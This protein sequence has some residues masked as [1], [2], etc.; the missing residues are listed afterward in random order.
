[1]VFEALYYKD[2]I[3]VVNPAGD[4]GIATLWSQTEAAYK[5]LESA[6]VDLSPE[7]SRI[8]V[9]ANLYGNGLPQ[10][11]RNLLWNPQIRYIVIVGKNLSGSR[12]WLLNFFEHGIEEVEFLG[13]KAFRIRVTD[14]NIDGEVTPEHFPKPPLF[15][16]LGDLGDAA[17]KDDFTKY[18][19]SLPPADPCPAERITPPPVP[20]PTVSRFPSEPRSHTIVRDTPMEAWAELIFRLVRFGYRN[21][22][23]K[24]ASGSTHSTEERVELQNVKVII[25]RPDTESEDLLRAYGFT[26]DDF[27]DDKTFIEHDSQLRLDFGSTPQDFMDYQRRMLESA[28]PADIGY[29]YGNRLR[30]Y[31]RHSDGTPVD[32]LAIA[33]RRLRDEP[34]SRHAYIS[35][36][37][38]SRDLPEGTHCP[39]FVTGFF[40]RFEDQLTFTATFR[41][42]NA[43]DAWPKNVYGLLAIQRFVADGAGMRP[44]PI[45]VISH[46]ISVDVASLEKAKRI[47]ESKTT[48]DVLDPATGKTEP[49][50][51]PNGSFAITVDKAAWE[52]VVE[53]SYNGMVLH[54]Y[55]GRSAE[56]IER[57]V[58]RDCA[59]SV[60]SHALYLGRE[61]TRK[62][63]QMKA[64]RARAE[65]S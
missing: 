3:R 38:N 5:V 20:E 37:D 4:V 53:H 40:R 64:D 39:C 6:G 42:H 22:V 31:F 32:S 36:W 44:G 8:A 17:T 2:R 15:T 57:Q 50:F 65:R 10:M 35:L 16:V 29:T 46:S 21:K 63:M 28:K 55:R 45:T 51:D 52:L 27:M 62:E 43:M 41:S 9:I 58:A 54:Q 26:P 56:E 25:E 13:A 7:T 61:L 30:G 34:E 14:R 1:M 18:F 24:H 59:L 49:R 23:A 19:A 47:A 12:E 33:I 11:L 48:D 60:M